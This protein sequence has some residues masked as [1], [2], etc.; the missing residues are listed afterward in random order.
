[1]DR[2]CYISINYD[3]YYK[4][5]RHTKNFKCRREVYSIN[6]NPWRE[7]TVRWKKENVWRKACEYSRMKERWTVSEWRS[8]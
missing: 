5:I 6:K 3:D 8:S 7:K 2:R 4:G 1:M